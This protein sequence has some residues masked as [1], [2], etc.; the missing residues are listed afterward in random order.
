MKYTMNIKKLSFSYL[1]SIL[2]V[3]S[4]VQL[5]ISFSI[6]ILAIVISVTFIVLGYL[7]RRQ[8]KHIIFCNKTLVIEK[9][10]STLNLLKLEVKRDANKLFIL[11]T[12]TGIAV[13]SVLGLTILSFELFDRNSEKEK[14]ITDV[15]VKLQMQ[16]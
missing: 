13:Y 3:C 15:L 8:S 11:K 6:N 10:N 1:G 4:F 5:F 14:F 2:L 7:I 16:G 12:K 9:I